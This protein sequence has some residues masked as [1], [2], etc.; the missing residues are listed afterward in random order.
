MH[1]RLSEKKKIKPNQQQKKRMFSRVNHMSYVCEYAKDLWLSA[2]ANEQKP[3]KIG[4][5][6]PIL[7]KATNPCLTLSMIWQ[8]API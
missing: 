6:D 7:P 3:L 4:T 5:H 2:V 1:A 8:R